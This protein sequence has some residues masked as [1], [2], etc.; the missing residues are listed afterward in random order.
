MVLTLCLS[1]SFFNLYPKH[2][3]AY[4]DSDALNSSD[5]RVSSH[6]SKAETFRAN[7][8][9]YAS[10]K[11]AL[12]KTHDTTF[13]KCIALFEFSQRERENGTKDQQP[14]EKINFAVHEKK[15]WTYRAN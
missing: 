2:I 4:A 11:T 13:S 12:Y 6:C 7:P 8:F 14:L 3:I 15:N 10:S 5:S 1:S 9:E